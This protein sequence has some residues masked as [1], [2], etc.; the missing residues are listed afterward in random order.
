VNKPRHSL[1]FGH[2]RSIAAN[3]LWPDRRKLFPWILA[4]AA[5]LAYLGAGHFEVNDDPG[6]MMNASGILSSAAP[7]EHL[8][9]SSPLIGLALKFLY[10]H[11]PGVPWYGVYLYL[12]TL[13]YLMLCVHLLGSI[14][15]SIGQYRWLTLWLLT[16][17]FLLFLEQLQ[18]TILAINLTSLALFLWVVECQ[19]PTHR[20]ARMPLALVLG[21]IGACIR[22]QGALLAFA[23]WAP[24]LVILGAAPPLR[25]RILTF[26]ILFVPALFIPRAFSSFYYRQD[27][28]WAA[29]FSNRRLFS[30]LSNGPLSRIEAPDA[31]TLG[32]TGW[33]LNDYQLARSWFYADATV[34]T[35][36]RFERFRDLNRHNAY[37]Y[38]GFTQ[39]LA[40]IIRFYWV[41]ICQ[42]II[43]I[44][45]LNYL[46]PD[47]RGWIREVPMIIWFLALLFYFCLTMK[48]VDRVI[49][50]MFFT[51][52]LISFSN[53][54]LAAER[55]EPAGRPAVGRRFKLTAVAALA[56]FLSV[57]QLIGLHR[58][59][60][61]VREGRRELFRQLHELQRV[62]PHGVFVNWGGHLELDKLSPLSSAA[63]FAGFKYRIIR[64]GAITRSPYFEG[65]V[66]SLGYDRLCD[67]LIARDD[68]F[69]LAAAPSMD[70]LVTFYREHY[71]LRV[72]YAAASPDFDVWRVSPQP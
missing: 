72:R 55:D 52:A 17:Y 39:V 71:N 10:M 23:L 63:E 20:S 24:F 19:N 54:S 43:F 48:T 33:S 41:Y 15:R 40:W 32:E 29:Y 44:A 21:F 34:F 22:E 7:G 11:F 60:V 56:G 57:I 67:A 69:V 25:K 46:R 13:S 68:V 58:A 26:C 4:L 35:P 31:R 37:L 6:M 30:N 49:I 12:L 62:A 53:F 61:A 59:S 42:L 38:F 8:I 5:A 64:L 47:G 36:A 50:P 70:E 18:F 14:P 45:Y 3:P 65:Q 51:T 1:P 27:P 9:F 28:G 66:R 16:P 2:S